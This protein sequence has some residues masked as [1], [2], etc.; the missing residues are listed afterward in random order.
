MPFIDDILNYRSVSVVGTEK[1]VGKTVTLN[2]IL[3]RLACLQRC[4]AVTSIGID[5]E[6][7]DQ[8]T[9]TVKPDISITPDT[10]FITSE[11]H[12][13]S[14]RI[15][16]D[17]LDISDYRTS[18]GRLVTARALTMGQV[19]LSGPSDT[20][21]LI[22]SIADIRRYG[23]DIMMVDGAL[24][25]M[26]L[27]SPTVTDAMV[28]ATGAAFSLSIPILVRNTVFLCRLIDLPKVEESLVVSLGALTSGVY[29]ITDEDEIVKLSMQS[30]MLFERDKQELP[31]YGRRLYVSGVVTDKLLTYIRLQ[32]WC[33]GYEIIV[34]DFTKLF[35]S[36]DI[37]TAFVGRGGTVKVLYK[38]NLV[39]VTVNPVS[40]KGYTLD[41]QLLCSELS[42]AIHRPVYDVRKL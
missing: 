33:A 1:N 7:I 39:G 15:V 19:L 29:A 16:A 25:R 23:V 28:L 32:R 40:P 35:V 24:S 2:Y 6:G 4:V 12:Y 30:T 5:G 22:R 31:K 42:A 38:S 37:F 17:I 10:L 27:A 20:S 41:S 21:Q 13:R 26:S 9:G 14:K 34:Q 3:Q 11:R 36:P 18:L 8:V